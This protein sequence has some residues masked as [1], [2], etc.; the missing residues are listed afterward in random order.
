MAAVPQHS[1]AWQHPAPPL[2]Q[3]LDASPHSRPDAGTAQ[4][5]P[6]S[7]RVQVT[8]RP[9]SMSYADSTKHRPLLHGVIDSP[10]RSLRHADPTS[11]FKSPRGAVPVGATSGDPRRDTMY[12]RLSP[13]LWHGTYPVVPRKR[14]HGS[15]AR[16]VGGTSSLAGPRGDTQNRGVRGI[17][18]I[19][20]PGLAGP[21]PLFAIAWLILAARERNL[22]GGCSAWESGPPWARS[23]RHTPR[24]RMSIHP[25]GPAQSRAKPRKAP[26]CPQGIAPCAPCRRTH[27]ASTSPFK[28]VQS[29]LSFK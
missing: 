21:C 2:S 8:S 5:S 14:R 10:A 13:M 15:R 19:G 23:P 27:G 20:G 22:G 28:K 1:F 7:F 3:R 17:C 24:R 6:T 4:Q 25:R 16:P 26:L 9:S 11:R 18:D 29:T 12:N